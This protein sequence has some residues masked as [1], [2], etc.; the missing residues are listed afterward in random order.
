VTKTIT[1]NSTESNSPTKLIL[2]HVL[3]LFLYQRSRGLRNSEW[4][5]E[6]NKRRCTDLQCDTV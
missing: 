5:G 2:I 1:N 3:L 6:E 4:Y